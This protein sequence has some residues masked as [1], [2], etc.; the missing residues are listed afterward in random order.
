[1][2][3][4]VTGA[5]GLLGSKVA[6]L[7][8]SEGHEVYSAFNQHTINY[9]Y[10]VKMDLTDLDSCRRVF[11]NARPE[12][13]VHSAALTNVDLCEVEKETA[14]RINVYGTELIARLCK[15]FNCFMV[16]IS[17][18]YVFS[19]EKGLYSEVDQPDPINYYGYTKLKAEEAV[20]SILNGYCIVRTSVI[21]GSKPAAGKI[22]F[23]LW[24]L[25]SLKQKRKINVVIDQINSPTLNTSLAE[26]ILEILDRKLMGLYHIAGATPISRYDFAC[27]LAEEFKLERELIQPTTSDKIN[28]VA[29]RPKNASLNVAKAQRS[30]KKKPLDIRD[31][32]RILREELKNQEVM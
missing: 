23:A 29:K 17:T 3:I 19:G 9:G 15:E 13:V 21:F 8:F 5:S 14:W 31:A 32:I 30:L 28:W 2:K 20:R 11:E 27:L 6:E 26:A 7:A 16:F 12:A 18:D 4:L 10:P 22:N 25:E 1:M 24:V